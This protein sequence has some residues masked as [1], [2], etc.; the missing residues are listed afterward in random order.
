MNTLRAGVF[1]AVAATAF[2]FAASADAG[3]VTESVSKG[4]AT[5]HLLDFFGGNLIFEFDVANP[6]A[7][8][9]APDDRTG[10]SV[11]T[12]PGCGLGAFPGNGFCFFD[13]TGPAAA[14]GIEL[15]EIQIFDGNVTAGSTAASSQF[16]IGYRSTLGGAAQVLTG[17]TTVVTTPEPITVAVFGA[18]IAGIMALRR[19][20][21]A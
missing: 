17:T 15:G 9:A 11:I 3:P 21:R 19:T 18:G 20:R 14:H 16:A 7:T 1:A 2:A 6:N 13:P 10:W 12:G 5:Y 4:V 8:S